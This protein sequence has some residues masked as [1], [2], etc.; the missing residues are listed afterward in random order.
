MR[1]DPDGTLTLTTG[2]GAV[3]AG[4]NQLEIQEDGGDTYDFSPGG[5]AELLVPEEPPAFTLVH[6]GPVRATARVSAAYRRL[7]TVVTDVSVE[8]DSPWISIRVELE[9]T[10]RDCRLRARFP[11]R[12]VS[13]SLADAP[14][15]VE[16][17]PFVVDDREWVQPRAATAPHSLW[18][19]AGGGGGGGALVVSAP[20]LPEHE[21][22]SGKGLAITLLRCTGWLSRGDLDTREGHAGPMI[23][24]PEAQ[25]PGPALFEYRLRVFPDMDACAR[26]VP[27]LAGAHLRPW[28][29]PA[30]VLPGAAPGESLLDLTGTDFVLTGCYRDGEAPDEFLVARFYNCR[31]LPVKGRVRLHG[32]VSSCTVVKLDGTPL[33]ELPISGDHTVEVPALPRQIITVRLGRSLATRPAP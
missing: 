8:A 30:A 26:E 24:V 27:V 5:S 28:S 16:E 25:C 3:L 15:S 23:A 14:F 13:R 29:V 1:C 7:G 32:S 17:R 18:V 22:V 2:D 20:G 31:S 12:E 10:L 33:K 9:N 4:L 21:V 11:L 6:E 19:A